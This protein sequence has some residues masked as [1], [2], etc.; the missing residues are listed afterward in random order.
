[1]LKEGRTAFCHCPR[2]DTTNI[3]ATAKLIE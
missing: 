3:P 1:M 2:C